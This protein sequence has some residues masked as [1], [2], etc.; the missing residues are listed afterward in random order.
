[1][2]PAHYIELI[3]YKIYAD[4][5]AEAAQTYLSF[6]WWIIE[7]LLYMT[8]FYIVFGLLIERGGG[9][10]FIPFLLCGLT[11]WKWF[12]SS[13]RVG[14]NSIRNNARLMSQVYLPKVLFPI[15]SLGQTTLKFLVVMLLL[16]IFLQIFTEG[17]RLSY[18]ALPVLIV[19]QLLLIAAC[20]FFLAA[21][22][23]FLPDI[24]QLVGNALVLLMFLS[25]VFYSGQRIPE[26]YRGYFFMNPMATLID[27]YRTVM[28]LGEWPDW[29]GLA[30]IAIL[31]LVV[32]FLSARL[33]YKYD[34]EYPKV[35]G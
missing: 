26:E 19:T 18:L 28:L 7:P 34:R 14:S 1:M 35:L 27:E 11:V 29:G 9:P 30:I 8:V 25:G 20:A 16:I 33:I 5:R 24:S 3:R 17:V 31:S 23:P 13:V 6:L 2:T 12:D 4:L 32:I 22:V 21:W 10:E 15:I